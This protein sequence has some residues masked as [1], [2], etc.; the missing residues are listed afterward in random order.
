MEPLWCPTLRPGT[1]GWDAGGDNPGT[2]ALWRPT[3]VGDCR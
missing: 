1:R 2:E 3:L